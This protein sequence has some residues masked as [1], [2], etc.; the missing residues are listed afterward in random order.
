MSRNERTRRLG[1]MGLVAVVVTLSMTMIGATVNTASA[2]HINHHRLHASADNV[3]V[4]SYVFGH[5]A[6]GKKVRGVFIPRSFRMS[7]DRLL[8]K[9]VLKG[10]IVRPGKDRHFVK[11]GVLIPVS[12]VDGRPVTPGSA[13]AAA[14]PPAPGPGA[15]NVLNL[16]L[17][18]LDL[19][20]LGLRVHLNEVVLNIT[21]QTGSGQLLGNLLCAVAGLLDPGNALSGLLAQLNTLLNQIL[22]A[23]GTLRA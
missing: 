22:G 2:T 4:M 16:D 14:F 3:R 19:N 20:I 8:A 15:C 21:A 7:G 12:S 11:R 1:L 23:L 10:K 13:R 18:P 17:G 5:T 6:S 9:G